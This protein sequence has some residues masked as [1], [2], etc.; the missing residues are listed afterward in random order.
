MSNFDGPLS[1]QPEWQGHYSFLPPGEPNLF[2]QPFDSVSGS[3]S[4]SA[5]TEPR[6]STTTNAVTSGQSATEASA[7]MD[8]QRLRALKAESPADET[9]ETRAAPYG[10]KTESAQEESLTSTDAPGVSL[11]SNPLSSASSAEQAQESQSANDDAVVGKEEDDD[12]VMDDD[13]ML[14]VDGEGEGGHP[15]TAAERTAARRKMKRFR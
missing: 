11:G 8:A 7:N 15:Q 13:D 14:D 3:T 10:I 9:P 5:S 2:A 6:L 1:T 12:E 4:N